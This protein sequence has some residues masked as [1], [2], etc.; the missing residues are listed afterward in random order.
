MRPARA[1]SQGHRSDM[2]ANGER[3]SRSPDPDAKIITMIWAALVEAVVAV[4][5]DGLA[6]AGAAP[7][8]LVK[9]PMWVLGASGWM[10]VK[11]SSSRTLRTRILRRDISHTARGFFSE[12]PH[13]HIPNLLSLM[14]S[15]S[16]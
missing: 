3:R 11:A 10:A 7:G 16:T 12:W 4:A 2:V 5:E 8:R 6:S 1:G 14:P 9:S 13:V 15:P